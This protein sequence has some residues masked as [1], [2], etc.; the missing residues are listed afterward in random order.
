[1]KNRLSESATDSAANQR[2]KNHWHRNEKRPGL[3]LM[4][5][6][7]DYSFHGFKFARNMLKRPRRM[8]SPYYRRSRGEKG[9]IAIPLPGFQRVIIG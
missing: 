4:V 3:R 2:R 8:L 5:S 7:Y 9:A 1:M 6:I